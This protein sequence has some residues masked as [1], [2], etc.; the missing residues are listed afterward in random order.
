MEEYIKNQN[1]VLIIE[2]LIYLLSAFILFFIGK[3]VYD[4]IRRKIDVKNEL[5]QKDNF[6]FALANT[7]YYIGLLLAIG[8][9][10]I[11]P[12][13]GLWID[14]LDIG[15]YG[16][17]AIILLNISSF[18][19]DKIILYTF[20]TKK[21]IV[22]DQNA[23]TGII[24]AANMVASGTI[25]M[26]AVTGTGKSF[27]P[28]IPF[29]LLYSG[30]ITS[31]VFWLAGQIVLILGGLFY[32]MITPFNVHEHVEKDN[33]AVGIG[34]S[35]AIVALGIL[36]GHSI[37]GDFHSWGEH[38]MEMTIEMLIGFILLPVV[39]LATDKILL[40]GEN[41]TDELINQEKPNIGASVIE[42]FAYIGGAILITW[43][44]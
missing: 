44:L 31:V 43:C 6:A 32:N 25:I 19:N 40:P 24:E 27:F 1:L 29:G 22:E 23:G 33:I 14:V 10:I 11:G 30:I 39:R 20:S 15:V 13:S 16:L 7:G 37:S 26:G 36:I 9:A 28:D 17:L 8:S 3:L 12:S 42:A 35:G 41:L 38:F 18:I 5:V 2:T 21:E 4:Q 34:F